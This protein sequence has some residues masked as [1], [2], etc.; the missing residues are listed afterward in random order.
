MRP[1]S[2]PAPCLQAL[3]LPSLQRLKLSHVAGLCD[4]GVA[5]LSR[6]TGL[7]ELAVLAQHN[8]QLTQ[9][10]LGAL[11]TLRDL[12]WARD[13]ARTRLCSGVCAAVPACRCAAVD[14]MACHTRINSA[15]AR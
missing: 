5:S 7:L 12:R 2:A 13:C 14:C 8:R 1:H 6:L 9:G 3:S 10:P 15:A 11:A 4:A